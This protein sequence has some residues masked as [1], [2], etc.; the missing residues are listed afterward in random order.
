MQPKT[1]RAQRRGSSTQGRLLFHG[2][3]ETAGDVVVDVSGKEVIHVVA[4]WANS[5][6]VADD[7]ANADE[8]AVCRGDE[9]LLGGI[10]VLGPQCLFDDGDACFGRDFH[11]DAA[12]HTFEA[13]GVERRREDLAVLHR[14]NVGGSALGDFAALIEHYDLV[15]TLLVGFRNSPNIVEPG[16][17][18]YAGKRGSGVAAVFAQCETDDIAMLGKRRGVDDQV[19]LRVLFVALP[20]SH[21]VVDEVD[22]RATFG[23]SVGP[24]HLMEMH[25]HFGRG[26][27]HGKARDSGVLFEAAPVALV[28]ESLAA[29]DAQ[30][31]ENPP[32]ANQSR[33]PGRKAH[34]FDRQQA[35]VVKNVRVNHLALAIEV[36][37]RSL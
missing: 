35:F 12:G 31:G 34:L 29:R 3:G 5:D 1:R 10:K 24:N 2:G 21:R 7:F 6:L 23:D 26:V 37:D 11:E 30:G 27:R 20:E 15:E 25:A 36:W 13:S 17:S 8:V 19:H 16:D 4:Y 22:A 9:N 33:L 18:F 32:A 28:R 14:E